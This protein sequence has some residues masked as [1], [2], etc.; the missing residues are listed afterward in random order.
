M[1]ALRDIV[2]AK[3]REPR[4]WRAGPLGGAGRDFGAAL[5]AGPAPRLVAEFK[6]AS[7]SAGSIRPGADPAGIARAYEAAGAA[8]LSVLTDGRFFD[9]SPE[10]LLRAR[11]A[12]SLPVLRKDF[13][14]DPEDVAGGDAVLLIVAVLERTQLCEMLLAARERRIAALVEIHD[15]AECER[16]LEAGAGIVGI[17]NRDL[18]TMKVDLGTTG[19]LRARIPAGVTVVAGSGVRTRADAARLVAAG[20]D[21]ILVGESLMRAEDPGAALRELR[22]PATVLFACVH[23]A[24]RSQL[25]QAIFDAVADPAR[26]RAISAGTDPADRVHPEVVTALREQGIEIAGA[27]PRRLTEDLARSATLLVTMGCGE[28]CPVV[29]EIERDDWPLA[30]PQGETLARVR[31]IRDEI[32]QRVERLVEARAWRR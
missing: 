15:E 12:T 1:I 27:R 29:P 9:G 17:N 19:R 2:D 8:A 16:A 30:D 11:D 3:R 5:R 14:L 28:A 4:G 23:N 32:R 20:A 31:A 22:G 26:A 6:R 24:G 13:L 18:A 21:A 7:P 25:A 10:H